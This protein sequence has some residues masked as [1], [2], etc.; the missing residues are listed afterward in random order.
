MEK[1]DSL[2]NK[3][4]NILRT[5]NVMYIATAVDSQ[6]S[7]SSVFYGIDEKTMELY[8]F[9]FSPT[10]KG[11]HLRFN[12]KVQVHISKKADGREIKGVQVTGLC[13][14]VTDKELIENKIKPLIDT[15]S[16]KAFADYYSLQVAVWYKIKPTKIKYIDFYTQ[17]QFEFLEFKENQKSFLKNLRYAF[18]SRIKVWTQVTRA[19][20][21]TASIIPILLGAVIAWGLT[22][23]IDGVLLGITLLAGIFIHAGTNMLN[24]YFDHTSGG[25]ELNTYATPFN[26]GSRIIQT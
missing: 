15:S 9:T 2:K 21:F 6:P 7:V 23:Q 4:L 5:E 20:F 10:V 24:D 17:P 11:T 25:D 13:E 3:I 22:G 8:F 1:N 19:P 14:K 12:D 16:N 26:G 18:F